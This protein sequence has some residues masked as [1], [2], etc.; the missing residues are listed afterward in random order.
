MNWWCV[1]DRDEPDNPDTTHMILAPTQYEA[2]V[3]AS[4][5]WFDLIGPVE[6]VCSLMAIP[7]PIPSPVNGS[8]GP[9]P[10]LNR[11]YEDPMRYDD[12]QPGMAVTLIIGDYE[13][14]ENGKNRYVERQAKAVVSEIRPNRTVVV[15]YSC[16]FTGQPSLT[17]TDPMMLRPIPLTPEA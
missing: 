8:M 4:I 5:R 16:P 3:E 1:F 7:L 17:T 12:L 13:R 2:M 15:A 11:D 14:D 6:G 10:S 9:V